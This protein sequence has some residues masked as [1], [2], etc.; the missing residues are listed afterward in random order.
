MNPFWLNWLNS[1][2]LPD[3]QLAFLYRKLA[4]FEDAYTPNQRYCLSVQIE[5]A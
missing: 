2:Q 5:I 4:L 1:I 3:E